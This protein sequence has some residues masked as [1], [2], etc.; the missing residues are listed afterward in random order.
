[1]STRFARFALTAVALAGLA[2]TTVATATPAQAL[3]GPIQFLTAEPNDTAP[4]QLVAANEVAEPGLGPIIPLPVTIY[5]V[6]DGAN[7]AVASGT[8]TVVYP[9]AGDSVNTYT[10]VGKTLTV[11]CG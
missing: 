10:A 4:T 5:R 8:G 2:G 9:C 3:S 1:M 6:V 11:P 7:Q